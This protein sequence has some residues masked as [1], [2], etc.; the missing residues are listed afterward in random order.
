MNELKD[1]LSKNPTAAIEHAA[2]IEAAKDEAKEKAKEK[3]QAKATKLAVY[4]NA[5]S[6]YPKAIK[7]LALKVLAGESNMDAVEGA[8]AAYDAGQEEIKSKQ[9]QRE[10]KR[11]AAQNGVVGG[12]ESLSPDGNAN[13]SEEE[14]AEIERAKALAK[15]GKLGR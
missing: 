9:A 8:A 4:L 5:D 11:F 12:T 10:G 3:F 15:A 7:S 1:L 14:Q 6:T 2:A 13:T